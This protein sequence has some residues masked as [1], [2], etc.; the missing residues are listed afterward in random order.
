M[1]AERPSHEAALE[2][3]FADLLSQN[4]C[5]PDCLSAKEL[6]DVSLEPSAQKKEDAAACL[7]QALP[8]DVQPPNQVCD[9]GGGDT[10]EAL[11]YP[12]ELAVFDVS[13]IRYAL[14]CE[15]VCAVHHDFTNELA[16]VETAQAWHLGIFYHADQA[17]HVVDL[18]RWADP[19]IS[20]PQQ[21]LGYSH[22]IVLSSK[23]ALACHSLTLG[24]TL[25]HASTI[26]RK[27]AGK[28]AWLAGFVK[29]PACAL[30]LIET[31]ISALEQ[32][33]QVI[34]QHKK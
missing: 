28:R 8:V 34:D 9:A 4:S 6:L 20:L 18:T 10:H 2:N 5:D 22:L 31:L 26:W 29:E 16:F 14:P 27:K 3:Y 12:L 19:S 13:G 25:D 24:A 21:E 23:L 7:P 17:I 11:P 1:N 30:L 33:I 15:A 32:S